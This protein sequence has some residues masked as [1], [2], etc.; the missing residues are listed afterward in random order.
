M[1]DGAVPGSRVT[2]RALFQLIAGFRYHAR[3]LEAGFPGN[4]VR[5]VEASAFRYCA[6][7]L[8]QAAGCYAWARKFSVSDAGI[9]R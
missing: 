1:A 2:D 6:L 3:M 7:S 4:L 5:E 8:E 9:S